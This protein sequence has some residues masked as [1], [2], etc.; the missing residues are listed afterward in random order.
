MALSHSAREES[1]LRAVVVPQLVDRS[2][3]ARKDCASNLVIGKFY[4]EYL[5]TLIC[6]EKT[7]TKRD[8]KLLKLQL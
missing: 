3:P 2:L 1:N 6:I 5:F 4:I 7:K 8:P